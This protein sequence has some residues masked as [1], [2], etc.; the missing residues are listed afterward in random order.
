MLN[1]KEQSDRV[2]LKAIA[3]Y[4]DIQIPVT[5]TAE[6]YSHNKRKFLCK[7]DSVI[8]KFLVDA[9]YVVFADSFEK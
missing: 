2:G 8:N 1:K 3:I 5:I 6:Q 7:S 9:N 4:R